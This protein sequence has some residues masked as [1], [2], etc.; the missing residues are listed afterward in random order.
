MKR[1]KRRYLSIEVESRKPPD[2]RDLIDAVWLA[3]RDLYGE[4]GASQTSLYLIDYQPESRQVVLR[5]NLKALTL[6]RTSLASITSIA[7]EKAALQ[8]MA[9][10]G[11]IK[12]LS[13]NRT[14]K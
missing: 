3:V 13:K 10:S 9:I 11:T 12:S 1:T 4:Y 6:L 8:V 2:Q 14:P 7:G 5:V